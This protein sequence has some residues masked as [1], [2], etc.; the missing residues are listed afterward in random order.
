[1]YNDPRRVKPFTEI[2]IE[3]K[4][5]NR[6]IK[7]DVLIDDKLEKSKIESQLNEL[8]NIADAYGYAIGIARAY[9]ISIDQI[10]EWLKVDKNKKYNVIPLS[11][12]VNKHFK[13]Y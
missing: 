1:M 4:M 2:A 3:L 6:I 13:A 7:A 8:K 11:E 10:N 12:L 9:S 5:K